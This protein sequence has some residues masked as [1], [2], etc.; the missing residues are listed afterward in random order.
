MLRGGSCVWKFHLLLTGWNIA[1]KFKACIKNRITLS[2]GLIKLSEVWGDV[3]H[4]S[5][6]CEQWRGWGLKTLKF[7]H[8][9]IRGSYKRLFQQSNLR[10]TRAW[11]SF[12]ALIWSTSN[13]TNTLEGKGCKI[14]EIAHTNEHRKHW[15]RVT[16]RSR[17][18]TLMLFT[19]K[20]IT[21]CRPRVMIIS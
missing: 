14:A 4:S 18:L 13:I 16:P 11:I 7:R 1:T 9:S 3:I 10:N 19:K 2:A 8:F 21:E 17:A 12:S 15:S 20:T 5:S 6:F